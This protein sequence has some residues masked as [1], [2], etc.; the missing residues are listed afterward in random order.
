MRY[1]IVFLAGSLLAATTLALPAPIAAPNAE[2]AS[3]GL[4]LRDSSVQASKDKSV[5]KKAANPAGPD[6]DS[7][8]DDVSRL[9]LDTVC[10]KQI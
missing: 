9:W 1:S 3:T 8:T 4:N 7:D 5:V 6:T 10:V 2:A